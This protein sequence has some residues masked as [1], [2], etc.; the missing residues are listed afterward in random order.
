MERSLFHNINSEKEG[1]KKPQPNN[2]KK[3]N[4]KTPLCLYFLIH[5]QPIY[6]QLLKLLL[7]FTKSVHEAPLFGLS[8]EF[9]LHYV[10][11][12]FEYKASCTCTL[13]ILLEFRALY[14]LLGSLHNA[15]FG[16]D[17][18]IVCPIYT[19][20]SEFGEVQSG[21]IGEDAVI[22]VDLACSDQGHK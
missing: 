18:Q 1:K 17:I 10:H 16:K 6:E 22:I 15:L 21:R 7:K 8:S 14:S 4:P 2:K 9:D 11:R 19:V 13:R 5:Y 20:F 3:P 12:K